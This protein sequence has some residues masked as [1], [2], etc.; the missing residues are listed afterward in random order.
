MKKEAMKFTDSAVE[1][2]K[3][4]YDISGGAVVVEELPEVGDE[5]TI[6]E[7]Q[8]TSKD[9]YNW[10]AYTP[11]N[12]DDDWFSISRVSLGT[13]IFD[14]YEQMTSVFENITQPDEPLLYYFA[15]I[16]T[17]D[18][19][20]VIHSTEEGWSFEERVKSSAYTFGR[21][22]VEEGNIY[23][24]K[25][26]EGY[27]E[28]TNKYYGTLL[29]NTR[30]ELNSGQ[31]VAFILTQ[32]VDY[33]RMEYGLLFNKY[34]VHPVTTLPTAQEAVEN[35]LDELIAN[36]GFL[37][38]EI[39]GQ[40]KECVA[41]NG[42]YYWMNNPEIGAPNFYIGGENPV[43]YTG[44]LQWENI[45]SEVIFDTIPY[46]KIINENPDI[47]EFHPQKAGEI[48][49]SYWIYTN[50]EWVNI[51]EIP[52]PNL[53]KIG[54]TCTNGNYNVQTLP[55][56]A[57]KIVYDDVEYKITQYA[58]TVYEGEVVNTIT[59]YGYI[60]IPMPTQ[61]NLTHT[62]SVA[63]G[64]ILMGNWYFSVISVNGESRAL[65]PDNSISTSGICFINIFY[66]GEE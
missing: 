45:P 41:D 13:F 16:R 23:I 36:N 25:S 44:A 37:A 60:E 51:D 34:T 48:I 18:K 7:L 27:D 43:V 58:K 47:W 49:T 29:D 4:V 2:F 9:A 54:I 5:H 11:T 12:L 65:S 3:G 62:I 20:Y 57:L 19:L 32:V 59:Y 39:E 17:E 14:T 56:D 33:G 61:D 66:E 64:P 28:T 22:D 40:I 46:Q 52:D 63:A 8:E 6:Y 38:V 24:L 10:A 15:Y 35:Y 42:N 21:P 55:L 30:V 50:G 26:Y 1:L 53:I 31:D